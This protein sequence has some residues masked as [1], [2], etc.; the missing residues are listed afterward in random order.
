[1]RR[2]LIAYCFAVRFVV[3]LTCAVLITALVWLPERLLERHG[4]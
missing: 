1:M 2:L 4:D 3:I